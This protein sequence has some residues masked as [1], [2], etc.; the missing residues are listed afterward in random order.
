MGRDPIT[1]GIQEGFQ[2]RARWEVHAGMRGIRHTSLDQMVTKENSSPRK[3]NLVAGQTMG[4]CRSEGASSTG[5][6]RYMKT[7]HY[8]GLTS[9]GL[10]SNSWVG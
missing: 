1:V 7:P 4:P 2:V 3:E 8:A 5:F 6:M 10:G 9:N